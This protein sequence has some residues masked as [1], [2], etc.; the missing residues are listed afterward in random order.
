MNPPVGLKSTVIPSDR[1]IQLETEAQVRK[2]LDQVKINGEVAEATAGIEDDD[3]D[4]DEDDRQEFRLDPLGSELVEVFET[5]KAQAFEQEQARLDEAEAERARLVEA[6][7]IEEEKKRRDEAQAIEQERLNAVETRAR[8]EK[9]KKIRQTRQAT[10]DLQEKGATEM[11]AYANK[12]LQK[13][14]V[15]DNCT[16]F[17]SEFDRGLAD[18]PNILCRI[19]HTDDHLSFKLACAAGIFDTF[20]GR[21]GFQLEEP[22]LVFPVNTDRVISVRAAVKEMSEGNGQGV[23]RCSCTGGCKTNRCKCKQM[24]LLCKSRCHGTNTRANCNNLGPSAKETEAARPS[25]A[26]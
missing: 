22:S 4:D 18:A 5:E 13:A 10:S 2:L 20:I 12:V 3:D 16:F 25:K 24:G 8:A 1:W 11:L 23:I 17:I 9:I 15:G 21:N 19:I 26:T 14:N 7:A 6:Q